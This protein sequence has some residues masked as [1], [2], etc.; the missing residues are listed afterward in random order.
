MAAR[1]SA[2]PIPSL[3]DRPLEQILC[4]APIPTGLPSRGPMEL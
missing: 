3:G 4:G 2:L 1:G